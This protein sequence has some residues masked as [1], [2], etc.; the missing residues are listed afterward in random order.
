MR[1]QIRFRR[2][3]TDS[4][5]PNPLIDYF[6]YND[7]TDAKEKQGEIN[8]QFDLLNL[9]TKKLLYF[10]EGVSGNLNKRLWYKLPN[11]IRGKFL[12]SLWI[13]TCWYRWTHRAGH[14]KSLLNQ[15]KLHW[16]QFIRA[17][18]IGVFNWWD[19]G[20]QKSRWVYCLERS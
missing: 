20:L 7:L 17:D 13:D 16:Q 8:N 1:R 5:S 18:Q 6:I 2:E 11:L 12:L 10:D 9:S 3:L 4:N 19:F 14:P 15:A